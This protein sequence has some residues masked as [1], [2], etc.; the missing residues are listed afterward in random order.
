MK[1][2]L[3]IKKIC[4]FAVFLALA[5]LLP[6]LTGQIPEIGQQLCPMHIPILLAG[7][8]LGWKYGALLGFVAPLTR[9]LMFGQPAL[10]PMA[11][12][13]AFELATYGFLSG[14]IF[15][16]FIKK[17]TMDKKTII[18]M[19]VSLILAM[20]GGRLVWG[21]SRYL[22]GVF[23][24]NAFTFKMF[25]SGAI[26]TAWPGIVLQLVL[27]PALLFT[28]YKAKILQKYYE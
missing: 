15:Q 7:F 11:L 5:W 4:L 8:I 18:W 22:C 9:S 3:L 10:Y 13:M 6:L 28:L 1:Q 21:L 2:A 26:L 24:Q 25:L 14:F 12:C 23:A 19:Y 16:I 20:I 17:F 27:I